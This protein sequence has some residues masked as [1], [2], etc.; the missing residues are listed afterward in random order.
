MSYCFINDDID[1]LLKQRFAIINVW[2]AMSTTGYAYAEPI[3][4]SPLALCDAQSIA[5][6]D[7]V[8]GDLVYRNPCWIRSLTK[9]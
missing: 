2:R 8:A 7:L 1:T 4:E 5:P 6:T 3:Q 9:K